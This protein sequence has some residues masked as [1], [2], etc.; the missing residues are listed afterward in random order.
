MN[1]TLLR[2]RGQPEHRENLER[3]LLTYA[4]MI[5]LL[6]AFFLML[7]S[8]SVMS[9]GKFQQMAISVRQGF[10]GDK[11]AKGVGVGTDL[12]A[13]RTY[14]QYMQSLQKLRQYVEQHHL[15]GAI[16][17]SND[18]RG[19]VISVLTDGLLFKS[20]QATLQPQSLP[21]LHQ[22]AGL[23]RVLPNDVVVEGH[24]DDRPIHTLQFASNWELSAARAGAVVRDLILRE[25]LPIRRFS[26]AG[27]ADTRPLYPN[28]TP[29]HRARNRR[30]EIV[31]LRTQQEAEAEM[32]RQQEIARITDR[33]GVD[34]V[35]SS[36]EKSSVLANPQQHEAASGAISL[37]SRSRSV[38]P[39][40][41]GSVA[42]P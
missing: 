25:G 10:D 34:P 14:Q 17:M 26:A 37:G 28:D 12:A 41:E 9:R 8:M 5:T 39:S 11:A 18:R 24:T 22:I 23:L 21:L 33:G 27:Y 4:D 32:Q 15:E 30:V 13:E 31:L 42:E 40:D 20:G 36:G 38:A 6:M 2:G 16:H 7:Y 35:E 19:I 1:R 29:Q 3:W